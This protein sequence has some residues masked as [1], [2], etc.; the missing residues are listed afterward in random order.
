R[1][2][3]NGVEVAANDDA[4]GVQTSLSFS[5]ATAGYYYIYAGCFGS[6]KCSG[7]VNMSSVQNPVEPA[8]PVKYIESYSY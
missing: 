4:C 5:P 2:K 6:G 3:F 1:L 8:E 7:V